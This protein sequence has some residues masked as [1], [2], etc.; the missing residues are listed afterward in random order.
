M[1][2][3]GFA[4]PLQRSTQRHHRVRIRQSVLSTP[5]DATLTVQC[6]KLI[7]VLSLVCI[8]VYMIMMVEDTRDI[9]GI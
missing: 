1:F 7:E 5:I 4:L 9:T 3:Q 2:N 6:K 8:R